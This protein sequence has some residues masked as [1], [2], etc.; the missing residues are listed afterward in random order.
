MIKY[1]NIIQNRDRFIELIGN[2]GA[3]IDLFI[4]LNEICEYFK[5]NRFSYVDP[6]VSS[7][8]ILSREEGSVILLVK[9]VFLPRNVVAGF[10]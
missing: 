5:Y 7:Y 4:E 10:D 3:I 1:E 9:F 2:D 8:F 6:S